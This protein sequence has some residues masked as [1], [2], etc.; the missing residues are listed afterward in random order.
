MFLTTDGGGIWV[1]AVPHSF[2]ALLNVAF[3]TSPS[4]RY[5]LDEGGVL[6]VSLDGGISWNETGMIAGLTLSIAIGRNG[7]IFLNAGP[8]VPEGALEG[9]LYS[10][11][12]SGQTWQAAP[13]LFDIDSYSLTIDSCDPNRLYIANED[14]A[15]TGDNFSDIY[16]TSDAG[17]SWNKGFSRPIQYL[18][19]AI[20]NSFHAI[21]VGT[22]R[23]GILRS[24][25][26][27]KS[28]KNIGGPSG[29]ADSRNICVVNDNM[30]FA[31]DSM[32]NVWETT[33]SGGDSIVAP[34][35]SVAALIVPPTA[36]V[37]PQNVCGTIDTTISL[38]LAGCGVTSGMLDSTWLTGSVAFSIS[39]VRT[40]PR[41]LQE[42]DSI[43]IAYAPSQAHDTTELHL[44]YDLGNGTRDTVIELIGTPSLAASS[45]EHRASAAAYEGHVDSL[46]MLVDISSSLNLD[47]LW[48]FVTGV[49]ATYSWDSSVVHSISYVPP[50]G[51]GISSLQAHGN[52][53][54]ISISKISAAPSN[55][56]DLGMALFRPTANELATT[57]VSLPR[58]LL[59]LGNSSV[60][61]CVTQNEDSHWSVKDLGASGVEPV[62]APDGSLTLYPNPANGNV[63]ISSS[64][65]LG[66]VW[67]Q[68]YDMLGIECSTS[69]MSIQNSEP[70][71]LALPR[72]AGV[73]TI[74][75]RSGEKVYNLR[76][77][78]Q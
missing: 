26:Q 58:L 51:W 37:N 59:D 54:D 68:V 69:V 67:V 8:N 70:M 49:E 18:N 23:N 44:R 36:V 41:S 12:D 6:F 77:I 52:S 16:V 10:S 35:S 17:S 78:S 25:D 15:W 29:P 65:D 4:V 74:V 46:P 39:D 56:L 55:P 60:S 48:A 5:G 24:T 71:E 61:L 1:P 64:A 11:T 32:G 30:L 13:G 14:Y 45:L 31:F 3:G 42:Q 43:N 73:Y 63:W 22:V 7:T 21:Y 34:S 28:W 66:K 20:A 62:P 72:A 75:V 47:S 33:N 9:Q 19:G 50:S 40:V 76:V 2:S 38:L 27:G 53:E 57:W